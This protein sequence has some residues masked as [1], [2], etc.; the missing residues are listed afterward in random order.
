MLLT[1]QPAWL[2][3]EK[4]KREREGERGS[5]LS[6]SPLTDKAEEVVLAHVL[7][8]LILAIKPPVAKPAARV[9]L[10]RLPLLHRIHFRFTRGFM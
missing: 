5:C 6:S 8:Q 4:V 2:L 10:E 7:E 3:R 9:A 1:L